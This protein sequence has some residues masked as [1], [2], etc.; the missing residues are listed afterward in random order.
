MGLFELF[1][2]GG[3]VFMS[4]LTIILIIVL[5]LSVKKIYD[6]YGSGEQNP[7]KLKKGISLILEL[8]RFGLVFGVF[9]QIVGLFS[10]FAAIE[11]MGGVSMEMLAGG[12][13][14]SSITTMYGFV[15]LIISYLFYFFLSQK[16]QSLED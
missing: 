6:F 16:A 5:V 14:V 13:K 15:I 3:T 11:Q 9:G 12:L 2:S 1:Y 7:A 8:G 4:L 10:A